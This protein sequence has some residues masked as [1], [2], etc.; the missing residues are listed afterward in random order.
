MTNSMFLDSFGGV[1]T[2]G[3]GFGPREKQ[4]VPMKVTEFGKSFDNV[5]HIVLFFFYISSSF[6]AICECVFLTDKSALPY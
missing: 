6:F 4:D 3:V 1:Y 2:C 5:T